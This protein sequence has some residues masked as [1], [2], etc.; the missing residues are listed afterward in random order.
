MLVVAAG[1]LVANSLS[2]WLVGDARSMHRWNTRAVVWHLAGDAAGAVAVLAAA[3]VVALTGWFVADPLATL[4]IAA[5]LLFGGL[6]LLR[7]VLHVLVE[8][9]PAGLSTDAVA[10]ALGE[11]RES[12]RFTTCTPASLADRLPLVTAHLEVDTDADATSSRPVQQVLHSLG[13]DHTTLQ[14]EACDCGQGGL[15]TLPRPIFPPRPPLR[16]Q[17]P[18]QPRSRLLPEFPAREE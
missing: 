5:L 17:P 2:I 3:G 11:F 10:A 18:P 1:A 7:E 12:R 15:A 4:F 8:G 13:I 6:R 16:P 9:A 14:I